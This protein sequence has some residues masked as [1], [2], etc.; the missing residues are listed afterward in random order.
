MKKVLS[1]ITL[2][3]TLLFFSASPSLAALWTYNATNNSYS[4]DTSSGPVYISF[5]KNATLPANTG[6]R[7]VVGCWGTNVDLNDYSLRYKFEDNTAI[8]PAFRLRWLY[9]TEYN[10]ATANTLSLGSHHINTDCGN[11][12]LSSLDGNELG[13]YGVY[14]SNNGTNISVKLE[15]DTQYLSHVCVADQVADC[16]ANP[17]PPAVGTITISPNPVTINTSLSAS[18]T[19]VDPDATDTHTATINWGDGSTPQPCTIAET[20]GS[21]SVTCTR[22]AGYPAAN[23]YLTKITVSDGSLT[24][25]AEQYAY[26]YAPTQSGIFTA[27]QRF[28]SPAGALPNSSLTGTVNFGLSYKYKGNTPVAVRQFTMDFN[29]AN[30][31]F[32]ATSVSSLVIAKGKATL[33]GTGTINGGGTYKFLVVGVNEGGIRIKITTMNNNVVYDT[34][35]NTAP[36]ATPAIIPSSGHVIVK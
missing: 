11:Y 25:N 13:A 33:Q 15:G 32:N 5:V 35:P 19:F 1:T 17:N 20:N 22:S 4:S 34:Q 18:A 7:I 29:T 30:L 2:A 28:T 8:S 23:V 16:P 36:T 6:Y 24:G 26:V 12:G 21:G 10:A 14:G 27:A 31:H 3:I 9:P